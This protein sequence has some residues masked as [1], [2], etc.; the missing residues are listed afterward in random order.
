M[1][2]VILEDDLAG[3]GQGRADSGQ[4]DEDFGAVLA[5][6]HHFAHPLQVTDGTGEAVQNRFGVGMAMGVPVAVGMGILVMRMAVGDACFVEPC[7]F[8]FVHGQHL[9]LW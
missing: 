3:V 4:L 9:L 6:L 5:I 1:V 2:D 7:V 8:L